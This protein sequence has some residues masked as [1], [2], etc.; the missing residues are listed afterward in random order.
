MYIGKQAKA[1]LWQVGG[2]RLDWFV[3]A[4]SSRSFREVYFI[5]FPVEFTVPVGLH[6]HGWVA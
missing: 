2:T 1:N 6:F 5:K 3:P 4:N